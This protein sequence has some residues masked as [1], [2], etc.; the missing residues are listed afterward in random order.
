MSEQQR[1]GGKERLGYRGVPGQ[2]T[3]YLG[4]QVNGGG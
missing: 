3:M 1:R 4:I 2:G